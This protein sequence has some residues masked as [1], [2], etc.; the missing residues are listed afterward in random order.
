[1]NPFPHITK[2]I[3]GPSN[4]GAPFGFYCNE[5]RSHDKKAAHKK[6]NEMPWSDEEKA[7]AHAAITEQ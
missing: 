6:V 4:G 3:W 1:M 2:A 5:G 7:F